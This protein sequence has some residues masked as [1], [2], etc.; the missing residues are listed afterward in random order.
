MKT[1]LKKILSIGGQPGLY[2]YLSQARSGAVVESLITKRRTSFGL[3]A[4]ITSM[5]DISIYT[6]SGEVKLKEVFEKMHATLGDAEAPSGRSDAKVLK[7]FFGK[8]IPDY[9]QDRFYVSHMKKVV[10]WYNFL[11]QNASLDFIEDEEAKEETVA[12]ESK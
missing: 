5:A 8:V 12:E 4:K 1:D 7:E 9:D 2:L 3:N 6:D 11:K 10:D